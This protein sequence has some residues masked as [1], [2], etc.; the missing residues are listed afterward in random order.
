MRYCNTLLSCG[1]TQLPVTSIYL[2]ICNSSELNYRLKVNFINN[3]NFGNSYTCY[4]HRPMKT[5]L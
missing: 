1:I 4:K 5:D 2:Q 3:S